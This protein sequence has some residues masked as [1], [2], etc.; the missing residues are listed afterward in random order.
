MT[1]AT[2]SPSVPRGVH[3]WLLL[4]KSTKSLEAQARRSVAA[5]GLCLTDF[6]ILEALL[7]KGPL[8]VNALGKKILI[9]SG[10]MTTAV[11]RLQAQGLVVRQSSPSD[12]RARVLH[13]T[14]KGTKLIERLFDE[15]AR[16]MEQAF[17]CLDQ[18]E[19]AAFA[20]LLRKVGTLAETVSATSTAAL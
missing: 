6:G 20:G 14:S 3:L 2:K 9:T 16:D 4:W 13:L 18:R 19:R 12:R 11:D 5:T 10:S 8:A 1:S 15:H 17:S 7:H